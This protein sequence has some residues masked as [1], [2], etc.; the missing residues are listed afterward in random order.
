MKYFLLFVLF[1]V[2]VSLFR[3][4]TSL[5]TDKEVN[6]DRTVKALTW[7]IGLSVA[8]FVILMVAFFAGFITPNTV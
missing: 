2:L 3:A 5:I 8:L 1:L 4:L 7:R 6:S